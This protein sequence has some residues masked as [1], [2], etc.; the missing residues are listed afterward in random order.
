[1]IKAYLSTLTNVIADEDHHKRLVIENM[2][3]MD[4]LLAF[5]EF[6]HSEV[7]YGDNGRKYNW[8][9]VIVCVVC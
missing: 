5:V 9:L 2:N 1:M 7:S 8:K 3:L 4:L 6:S